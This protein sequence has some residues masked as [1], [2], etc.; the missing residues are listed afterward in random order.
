MKLQQA[1]YQLR[2]ENLFLKSR[3]NTFQEFFEKLMGLAYKADFMA[4][5]P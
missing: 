2:F 1:Y 3:G 5:R 4:C